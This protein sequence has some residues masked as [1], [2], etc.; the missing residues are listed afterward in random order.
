MDKIRRI[1]H[2]L[3]NTSKKDDDEELRNIHQIEA[4][5]SKLCSTITT[6]RKDLANTF[7]T[8][9]KEENVD[10][11]KK[12]LEEI[13][14]S[15]N[16]KDSSVDLEY[17]QSTCIH[18][19][20][21]S[22]ANAIHFEAEEKV[23]HE[24]ILERL[25]YEE[26]ASVGEAEKSYQKSKEKLLNA[27]TDLEI[28]QKNLEKEFS[29]THQEAVDSAQLKVE[30]LRDSLM[31]DAFL[32][33]TKEQEIAKTMAKL[34]QLKYEHHRQMNEEFA[35][36]LP[37]LT[38]YID[39]AR[40]RP[41]FGVDL[42]EH[43]AH[44]NSSIAV[45]IEKSCSLLRANGFNEK[46]LFRVNG[47]NGKIR[48]IKAAFDAGQ[49][50]QEERYYFNDPFS[51]CSVLKSYLRELP[52]PLL[53]NALQ[54]E[55]VA[56]V[57]L[58][59]EQRLQAFERLIKALPQSHRDNL[60]YLMHFLSDLEQYKD[61][62]S[63][64]AS[65]L[66]IVM[67]PN[68]M[69]IELNGHNTVGTV[70][71]ESFINN[72]QR[73]FGIPAFKQ[74]LVDGPRASSVL[75]ITSNFTRS[76][77]AVSPRTTRPKDKA[78]PP[79]PVSEK[80]YPLVDI[81]QGSSEAEEGDES[82][83]TP[84][85]SE[86]VILTRSF[87]EKKKKTIH[88]SAR[89]TNSDLPQGRPMS[90]HYAVGASTSPESDSVSSDE[91]GSVRQ[92]LTRLFEAT[93]ASPP[94]TAPERKR[95]SFIGF[96]KSAKNKEV[97]PNVV[98]DGGNNRTLVTLDDEPAVTNQINLTSSPPTKPTTTT[99]TSNQTVIIPPTIPPPPPASATKPKPPVPV[100]PKDLGE[101]KESCR[102]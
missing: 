63:M 8:G 38:K 93:E 58:D 82:F 61:V 29:S 70:I 40:P 13:G 19:V 5:N 92:N 21:N 62:T 95:Q 51:V 41:V 45:V 2:N 47:N 54:S 102:L 75:E 100:K 76:M 32:Q 74:N 69:G 57:K 85:K 15:N 46:G 59:G 94:P 67:G 4:R 64:N 37:E 42:T 12:K 17:L 77:S 11:R 39:T 44:T 20:M 53:T 65:N 6:F 26:L 27:Y 49:F 84:T 16:L 90:Y 96:L 101:N 98:T 52:D 73:L 91:I 86:A 30:T 22:I 66:A 71:V 33:S 48:R 60:I 83:R 35:K 31:T 18:K 87:T 99:T 3:V 97:S 14:L 43:L 55:W 10:K 50:D 9:F 1:K 78:P 25:V 56:A 28:A 81:S 72:A 88:N 79:P 68:I 7:Q 23:K 36:V 24:L 34:I 89:Q 80:V